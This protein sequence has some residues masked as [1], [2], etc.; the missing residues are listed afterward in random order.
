MKDL[1]KLKFPNPEYPEK[2]EY[3]RHK[4]ENVKTKQHIEMLK[5]KHVE[6]LDVQKFSN[7][8]KMKFKSSEI[9]KQINVN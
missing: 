7:L 8:N 3:L 5:F 1:N 4:N 2:P 9:Q 6:N